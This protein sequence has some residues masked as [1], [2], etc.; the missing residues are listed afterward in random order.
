M[1]K[2]W[3][4]VLLAYLSKKP[5]PAPVPVPTPVPVPVPVPTPVPPPPAPV[6]V[7]V[8]VPPPPP[9]APVPA[10]EPPP[11][12]GK[13][14]SLKLGFFAQRQLEGRGFRISFDVSP[15][16]DG[17]KAPESCGDYYNQTYGQV[18]AFQDGPGFRGDPVERSSSNPNLLVIA[19]NYEADWEGG[20]YKLAGKYTLGVTYPWLPVWRCQDFT[21]DDRG[22]A[23]G[24]G[25]NQQSYDLAKAK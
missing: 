6:P 14:T 13:P 25:N 1:W 15:L 4:E 23:H 17:V 12:C 7:P 3:L 5:A 16:V 9:P 22:Q 19:T 20:R 21:I 8:P 2:R 24:Y 11:A 18:L 10:P